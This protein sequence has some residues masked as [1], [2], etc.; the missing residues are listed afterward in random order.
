MRCWAW[1]GLP[2]GVA[3]LR[4]EGGWGSGLHIHEW[5][6]WTEWAVFWLHEGID[7]NEPTGRAA[8]GGL[9]RQGVAW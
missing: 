2:W 1:Q 3:S 6:A 9:G 4:L 8:A 5:L 7:I